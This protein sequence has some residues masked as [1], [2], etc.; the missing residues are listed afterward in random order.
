MQQTHKTDNPTSDFHY[1]AD[2]G[3]ATQ[4][5]STDEQTVP[6]R[7]TSQPMS[8]VDEAR[9]MLDQIAGLDHNSRPARRVHSS[10]RLLKLIQW[11]FTALAAILNFVTHLSHRFDFRLA[12]EMRK[13]LRNPGHFFWFQRIAP[14]RAA[15]HFGT[16]STDAMTHHARRY[17]A[18]FAMLV[19]AVIVVLFGGFS[20]L[21]TSTLSLYAE[22]PNPPMLGGNMVITG[23]GREIYASAVAANATAFPRRIETISVK[24]G[25]TLRSL[26]ANRNLSLDTL[27]W[28]NDIIDPD[29]ELKGGQKLVV[30]PVTGMLHIASAGD[31][32][33]KI[34]EKYG[35]D[36]KVILD[37]KFNNLTG[38]D[39]STTFKAL[40]EVMVP[41]GTLPVRDKLYMYAIRPNDTIKT[42]ADKFGLKPDTLLDNNDLEGG[43]KVSQQIRILPVDG[44]LY[45]VKKGDTLDGIATYL[46]TK[47]ENIINF[48]PNNVAPGLA[49]IE[50]SSLVVP[51]GNWP[52]P[53]AVEQVAPAASKPVA[54]LRSA[55]IN[56]PAAARGSAL[57]APPV[58]PLPKPAL[59]PA[60]PVL[61]PAA[62]A[63]KPAAPVVKS[64]VAAPP[65]A[66][67]ATGSMRWPMGGIITTYFGE[68]IWYG[69]HMG[70]DISTGCGAPIYAADGGTV[71]EAG[72][73]PYGYGINAVIDHANG[74]RTRYAHMSRIAVGLGQRVAKGQYVGA[75]GTTGNS[76]G[77][78]LHFEVIVN[79]VHTDPLRWLRG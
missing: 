74:I 21:A 41:G 66:G 3:V 26:A 49:L 69:I 1:E 43:L 48:R 28:A 79:G 57:N 14:E 77:C 18:H 20:G 29:T 39:E 34:A 38:D 64:V 76:T 72:W 40:Q 12:G 53:V 56:A 19:L 5:E 61:K 16:S 55:T 6:N 78:H 62:P 45:Q 46:Q 17:T 8:A 67:R 31:T 11:P 71:I 51:G 52:A 60:A 22:V 37:Y 65:G 47:P 15:E 44:V 58:A 35:V 50:G 23:D 13:F 36:P 63:P 25:E 4:V 32:V 24:D 10:G 59:K 7:F 42:V 33:G 73:S 2:S 68:R 70:L 30:P 9:A 54:P 75:E 27:L